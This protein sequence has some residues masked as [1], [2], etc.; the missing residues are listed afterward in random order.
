MSIERR[1]WWIGRLLAL[2]LILISLRTAYWQLWRGL[3]LNPV[4]LNPVQAARYYADLRGAPTPDPNTPEAASLS[5]LPQPVIQRTVQM[6]STI[7]RGTIYDRDGNVLVEDQGIRGDFT[8]VYN[9]PSLAHMLGYSSAI[10]TGVMGLEAT[11]NKELL[12]LERADTEIDRMLHRPIVGSS[13]HLTIDSDIQRAAA[14]A[15][16]GRPGA[17][18]ALD[19]K[20]GAVLAMVSAPGFDPNQITNTEYAASLPDTALIN[21]VTQGMYTPG[22]TFKV[23]T[24][25]AGLET[26]TVNQNTVFDFG[27]PKTD[28]N[29]QVYYT[30][31]VDGGLIYDFNHKDNRLS[32][33]DSLLYSANVAFAKIGL[34]INPDDYIA[35]ASRLGFSTPDY[36]RRFPLELPVAAP[37]LANNVEDIRTNNLLRAHTGYGQG[38]LL[39]TPLNMAMVVLAVLND[40]SI[41]VPYMVESI[42]DPQGSVIRGQPNREVVRG[43]MKQDTARFTRDSMVRLATLIWGENFLPVP[44]ATGGGKTGTAELGGNLD[45]HAWFIGFAEKDGRQVVIAV[46]MENAGSGGF[47]PFDIF[48]TVAA[49]ALNDAPAGPE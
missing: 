4:A 15:V 36:T 42:H 24:M 23:V 7:Q 9:E 26:G 2:L 39:T 45:P 47:V 33:Q 34:D 31:E 3:S 30:L 28:G 37:Q 20:T 17:V 1:T 5:Q 27:E 10:R 19:G 6:L 49:A 11:Y 29:G 38:E 35:I 22:S 13:L 40:G 21:R 48:K 8:R 43:V 16:A 18:V 46:I 44:G 14:Q 12:G 25:I 41:P 32:L